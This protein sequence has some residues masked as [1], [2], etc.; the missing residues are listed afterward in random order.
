MRGF[1]TLACQGDGSFDTLKGCQAAPSQR[2]G[3]TIVCQGGVPRVCQ[4]DAAL[5]TAH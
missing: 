4:G 5:A 3:G 1:D 2:D